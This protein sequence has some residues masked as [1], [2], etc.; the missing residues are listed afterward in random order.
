MRD[1]LCMLK[2]YIF[3]IKIKDIIY[4][5]TYIS[6]IYCNFSQNNLP[7]FAENII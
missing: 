6:L 3:V 7:Q 5:S 1:G 2:Y 4:V